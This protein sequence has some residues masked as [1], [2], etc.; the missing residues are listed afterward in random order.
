MTSP[1]AF[2]LDF[3]VAMIPR[4]LGGARITILLWITSSLLGIAVAIFLVILRHSNRTFLVWSSTG[5]IALIRGT[6]LL[7]QIYMAYFGLGAVMAHIPGLR[8][9]F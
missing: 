3:F 1:F 6:P 7:I 9:T 2:S 8:S 4:L 5:F